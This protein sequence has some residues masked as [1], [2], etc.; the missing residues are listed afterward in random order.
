VKSFRLHWKS[1]TKVA[2]A[3]EELRE[4]YQEQKKFEMTQEARDKKKKKSETFWSK[5]SSMKS[6]PKSTDR[7]H[8]DKIKQPY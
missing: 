8:A 2:I 4:A 5:K 7:S 6:A 1:G 3:R